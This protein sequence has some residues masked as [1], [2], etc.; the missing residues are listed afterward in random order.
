M[1]GLTHWFG[2]P[3]TAGLNLYGVGYISF[4]SFSLISIWYLPDDTLGHTSWQVPL[5][6]LRQGDVSFGVSWK[7]RMLFGH[8]IVHVPHLAHCPVS[9]ILFSAYSCCVFT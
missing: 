1:F 8:N 2:H 9:I 5:P 3:V 6:F 7:V 4:L